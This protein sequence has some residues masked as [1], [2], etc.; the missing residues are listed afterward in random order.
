MLLYV[1]IMEKEVYIYQHKYILGLTSLWLYI[2]L[3]LNIY[4]NG[5]TK[6]NFFYNI[7]LFITC[8]ISTIFWGYFFYGSLLHKLDNL[9]ATLS[10][11]FLLYNSKNINHYILTI[12]TLIFYILACYYHNK[13]NNDKVLLYHLLFRIIGFYWTLV[14]FSNISFNIFIIKTILIILYILKLSKNFEKIKTINDNKLENN[15]ISY[16][17][18]GIIE[19]LLIISGIIFSQIVFIEYKKLI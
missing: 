18:A 3:V 13:K 8:K 15:F 2:P 6:Y 14:I 17:N 12:L 10:F 1:L 7:L 4:E 5:L 11:I 9:F 16:Y 19:T